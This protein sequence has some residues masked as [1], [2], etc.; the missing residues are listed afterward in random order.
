MTDAKAKEVFD[1]LEKW[2]E[3]HY[4][5][6]GAPAILKYRLLPEFKKKFLQEKG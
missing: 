6:L 4:G 2:C 1:W 5:F 3:E